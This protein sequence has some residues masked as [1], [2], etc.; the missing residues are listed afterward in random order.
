VYKPDVDSE[1]EDEEE[2]AH[3]K[4]AKGSIYGF[5]AEDNDDGDW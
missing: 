1:D 4:A 3:A 2:A 5:T